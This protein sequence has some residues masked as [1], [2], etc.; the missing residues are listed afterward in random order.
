[1]RRLAPPLLLAL[2]FLLASTIMA[3]P[4]SISPVVEVGDPAPG[5]PAGTVFEALGTHPLFQTYP[6]GRIDPAM[7]SQGNVA[8][9]AYIGSDGVAD[10]VEPPLGIWREVDGTLELI[11]RDGDPAPGTGSTFAAFPS[12]QFPLTPFMA[13]GRTAFEATTAAGDEGLW[14]DLSRPLHL[15]AKEGDQLPPMT[16]G[17]SLGAFSARAEQDIVLIDGKILN[18]GT[19]DLDAEGLWRLQNG[20]LAGIVASG[21]TAPGVRRAVFGEVDAAQRDGSVGVFDANSAGRVAFT[22]FLKGRHIDD[23]ND[24][25]IWIADENG[26][27]RL[28]LRSGDRTPVKLGRKPGEFGGPISPAFNLLQLNDNG[29][30]AFEA[31]VTPKNETGFPTL[32][33]NRNG[34]LEL[35]VKGSDKLVFGAEPGDPAPGT[36][37]TFVRFPH[38]AFNDR[39]D[40][41]FSAILDFNDDPFNPQRAGLWIDRGQGV[42]LVAVEDGPVPGVPGETFERSDLNLLR[43]RGAFGL[44]PNGTVLY[45]GT[46]EDNAGTF[47]DGLFRQDADGSSVLLLREGDEV[48]VD[49]MVRTVSF[50]N[51]TVAGPTTAA[52]ETVCELNFSD[53]GMGI[54]KVP[55]LAAS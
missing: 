48:S 30:L 5:F 28:F 49:G 23:D 32:W 17:A 14:S 1:M 37:T 20:T 13:G 35:V 52:G 54:Y 50:L 24:E 7:D 6:G 27:L 55:A 19:G 21:Q 8:F 25:G 46:Y 22:G 38:M 34:S 10:A 26:S 12:L 18:S 2:I 36:S 9:S 44:Q 42:E 16:P 33:T 53:G 47:V 45:M 11:A 3:A 4:L 31:F 43:T 41:L 15:V 40:L 39:G 29:R 51:C